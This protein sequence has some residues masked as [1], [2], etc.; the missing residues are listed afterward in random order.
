MKRIKLK[1][2]SKKLDY[3]LASI[4]ILLSLFGLLMV[5]EASSVSALR[6]LD[7]K[8]YF[9]KNQAVWLGIGI[10]LMGI[11]SRIDYRKYY[12]LAVPLLIFILI[13]L[14]MVFL[15]GI[16][17]KISGA[18]RWVNLGLFSFQPT[19]LAKLVLV[20]YLSA[21]FTYKEKN[22]LLPFIILI[23]LVLGLIVLEPDLGTAVIIGSIAIVL[24]FLSGAPLRQFLFL[25]P[26]GLLAALGL[27]LASPYR[28]R[29]LTTFINPGEDPLGAS[30][31]VRQMLLALGSGGLIGTGIGKSRQKFSYLP[32]ATTDSIFAIIGEEFGFIGASI[33]LILFMIIIYR[34]FR[35]A[36]SAS[37]R[38]GKLLAGGIV[39]WFSIQTIINLGAT[40]ALLPLTGVPLLLIS[41][42]GSSL[43]VTFYSIGILLNI[44]K[45]R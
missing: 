39:S 6:E 42:G 10:I 23:G 38:F 26:T 11:S 41:Y 1:K 24:Y 32:E 25:I 31:H 15:P 40:A 34:G 22:R 35:I 37:T 9:L 7:N 8:Y 19:E 33:V 17:L 18:H 2:Q 5:F 43:I 4:A 36:G 3:I 28:Y 27:A 20:I 45:Q 30:Y 29:R 21:W 14:I 44:S 16:G 13:A 12:T